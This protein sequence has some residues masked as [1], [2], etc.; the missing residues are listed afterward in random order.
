MIPQSKEKIRISK[1]ANLEIQEGLVTT[2]EIVSTLELLQG[3][4]D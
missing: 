2:D 3:Y 4:Y 1:V